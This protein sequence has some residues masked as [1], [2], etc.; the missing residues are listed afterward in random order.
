MLRHPHPLVA[1]LAL[2]LAV[3]PLQGA[4]AAWDG[5]VKCYLAFEND[6]TVSSSG[7]SSGS[8]SERCTPDPA[9]FRTLPASTNALDK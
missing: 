9:P 3:A 7:A 2:L 4:A 8:Y 6:T 1:L 5:T